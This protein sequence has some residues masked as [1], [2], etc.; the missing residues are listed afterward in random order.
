VQ[1]EIHVGPLTTFFG[2]AVRAEA[3]RAG[4]PEPSDDAV[5]ERIEGWRGW[6]SE[7]LVERGLLTAP[8]AWDERDPRSPERVELAADALRALKLLLA[9]DDRRHAPAQL[10]DR[11][12]SD[13]EWV[14]RAETGF[15]EHPYAQVM[16]PEFWLPEADLD[17]TFAC[18][19]PDGHEVQT[20]WAGAL[21]R[22]LAH[23]RENVLGGTPFDV[24]LWASGVDDTREVITLA[25]RAAATLENLAAHALERGLP[26]FWAPA[27]PDPVS[28]PS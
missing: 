9:Y 2:P 26:M 3:A 14:A 22:Q 15:A 1:I 25:R 21:A 4:A 10:P 17:F 5:R 20:G 19:W 28:R 8:L 27:A 6:I 7:G 13:A 23:L 18:P 11:P 16:V 12:E 24:L